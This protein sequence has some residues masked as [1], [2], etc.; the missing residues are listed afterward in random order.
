MHILN[1]GLVYA[2][3]LKWF[4]AQFIVQYI[5]N[6]RRKLVQFWDITSYFIVFYKIALKRYLGLWFHPKLPNIALFLKWS[7][8]MQIVCAYFCNFLWPMFSK[9]K[10]GIY[11]HF[12]REDLI[13]RTL[14][15]FPI[16]AKMNSPW[17]NRVLK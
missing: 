12:F 14:H 15:G 17:K 9:H 11:C 13:S 10:N 6:R 3:K 8:N 16:F 1:T 2:P 5:A 7:Y 4:K